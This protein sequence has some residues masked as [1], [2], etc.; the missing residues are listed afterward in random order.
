MVK[1]EPK[2]EE[3]DNGG[4]RAA[5]YADL[6][7]DQVA[8]CWNVPAGT[9]DA[10]GLVVIEMRIAVDP[11]ETVRQAMI[12]DQARLGSDSL[13]RAAAKSARR[14]FFNPLCRPLHLPP[15]KYAIWKDLIVKVGPK[16]T[17]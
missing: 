14:A 16:D 8:R 17:L 6:V 4:Q 9:R 13:F 10:K 1:N 12:V 15:H 11:D 7:R 2:E 5:S 3:Q